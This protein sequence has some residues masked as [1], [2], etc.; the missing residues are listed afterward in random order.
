MPHRDANSDLLRVSTIP[1]SGAVAPGLCTWSCRLPC[2]GVHGSSGGSFDSPRSATGGMASS[3]V[4][5][6]LKERTLGLWLSS[7][8]VSV[9][10][11]GAFKNFCRSRSKKLECNRAAPSGVFASC[12][13][14]NTAP[15]NWPTV[16]SCCWV[17]SCD[18]SRRS[19]R[20]GSSNGK[21]TS[22]RSPCE[23]AN[24]CSIA[25]KG[26]KPR[27]TP[28]PQFPVATFSHCRRCSSFTGVKAAVAF[29]SSRNMCEGCICTYRALSS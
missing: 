2:C 14:S 7:G 6:F 4:E 27:K 10:A 25:F 28:Q 29:S 11:C 9:G 17:K 1:S 21:Y 24:H 26:V 5:S 23:A 3:D 12:A 22:F 8:K 19:S 20:M 16:A 18:T 15:N 13:N